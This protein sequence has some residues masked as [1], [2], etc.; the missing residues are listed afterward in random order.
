MASGLKPDAEGPADPGQSEA[1]VRPDS[2]NPLTLAYIG[3]AVYE[4]YVRERIIR[5]GEMSPGKMNRAAVGKVRAEAQAA[6]VD[7]LEP[8][9]TDEEA[10]VY[11]RGR[12]AKSHTHAKHASLADYHKATGLEAV[13]GY[14]YLKDNV[15]RIQELLEKGQDQPK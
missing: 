9:F 8:L 5:A 13:L 4:L 6:L 7:Q 14:L 2:L 10:D 11:R 12:N 1:G 15:A 3:D